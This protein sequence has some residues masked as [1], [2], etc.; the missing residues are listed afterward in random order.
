MMLTGEMI[1]EVY[2]RKSFQA[3]IVRHE[4]KE[5]LQDTECPLCLEAFLKH[6]KIRGLECSVKHIFHIKCIDIL[7]K[8]KKECPLCRS[9]LKIAGQKD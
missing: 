2:H 3:Y 7:K 8:G 9:P 4:L 5:E 6:D 1:E